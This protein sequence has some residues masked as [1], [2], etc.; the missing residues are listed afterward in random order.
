MLIKSLDICMYPQ[1]TLCLT[2]SM[3]CVV[4]IVIYI[5]VFYYGQNKP[6]PK[7]QS[8]QTI[9]AFEVKLCIRAMMYYVVL[10][11]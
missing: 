3:M 11:G 5:Y 4:F 2:I 8:L 1:T 10:G 7:K 6:A 9:F